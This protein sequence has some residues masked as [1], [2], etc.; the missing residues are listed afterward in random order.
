MPDADKTVFTALLSGASHKLTDFLSDIISGGSGPDLSAIAEQLRQIG[1]AIAQVQATINNFMAQYQTTEE[2]NRCTG[3]LS[4]LF[5][6]VDTA[7]DTLQQLQAGQ[8]APAQALQS[9]EAVMSYAQALD[10]IHRVITGTLENLAGNRLLHAFAG[11]T[12]AAITGLGYNPGDPAPLMASYSNVENYFRAMINVQTKAALLAINAFRARKDP[13][14]GDQTRTALGGNVA[15]QC[16]FFLSAVE[17]LT[18]AYHHDLTLVDMLTGPPEQNPLQLA[19]AF[20]NQYPVSNTAR[21]RLWAG[22]GPSFD[23]HGGEALRTDF[24][25]MPLLPGFTAETPIPVA[26]PVAGDLWS[27][28]PAGG[29]SWNMLR[30]SLGEPRTRTYRVVGQYAANGLATPS[31]PE[32]W[33]RA[34]FVDLAPGACLDFVGISSL[35]PWEGNVVLSGN[36]ATFGDP[37]TVEMWVLA[38]QPRPGEEG[39]LA[40]GRAWN[41]DFWKDNP[42]MWSL[43]IRDGLLQV[44]LW[45]APGGGG[46]RRIPQLAGTIPIRPVVPTWYHVALVSDAHT[47]Q[48]YVDGAS[49]GGGAFPSVQTTRMRGVTNLGTINGSMNEVRIWGRALS[50]NE[51]A[52]NMHTTLRS[53]NALKACFPFDRGTFEDVTGQSQA[54]PHEGRV[55]WAYPTTSTLPWLEGDSH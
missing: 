4:A 40:T 23:L 24:N 18:V 15:Q 36:L 35:R 48:L 28:T 31:R 20:V 29:D 34:L 44:D 13:V 10:S 11:M 39:F 3:A 53:G 55:S 51:I 33:K 9:D 8:V 1:Q 26:F 14:S 22:Q 43:L 19:N 7:Y 12:C 41:P 38:E 46:D 37:F 49:A 6:S 45:T 2:F 30:F 50:Q 52:A 47:V 42:N 17:E 32:R 21:L 16:Q 27:T 5:E 25:F 54:T